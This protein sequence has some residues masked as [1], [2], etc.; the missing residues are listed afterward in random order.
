MS[1]GYWEEEE[2]STKFNGKTL[3]RILGLVR[4]RWRW[5]VAFL[6]SVAIVSA[7]E[8]TSRTWAS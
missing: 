8:A 3:L 5:V 1:S 6:V 2:F 4:L 7:L